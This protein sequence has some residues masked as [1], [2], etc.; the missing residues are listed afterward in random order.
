MSIGH[1]SRSFDISNMRLLLFLFLIVETLAIQVLQGDYSLEHRLSRDKSK[2]HVTITCAVNSNSW[3]GFG[4]SN[5]GTMQSAEMI[6]G[7]D[8]G[9]ENG[10]VGL[11]ASFSHAPPKLLTAIP[12]SA[13]VQTNNCT[14][15]GNPR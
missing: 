10:F 5:D 6:L 11:F 7:F 15:L 9:S 14:H 1:K 3:I 8:D 12:G 2:V 13:K 4:I